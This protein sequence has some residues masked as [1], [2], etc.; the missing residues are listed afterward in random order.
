MWLHG[1]INRILL[2]VVDV[3]DT[4]DVLKI[5][6]KEIG[7]SWVEMENHVEIHNKFII[8]YRLEEVKLTYYNDAGQNV[9]YLHYKGS[10]K[11]PALRKT[12]VKMPAKM[13]NITALFNAARLLIT[14][15]IKT[16]TVGSS[17]IRL[18][19]MTFE[20]PIDDV[21]VVDKSKI[22]SEELDEEEKQ[23]RLEEKA[24][25]ERQRQIRRAERK[26]KNEERR[27]K[28][29]KRLELDKLK[30]KAAS[31]RRFLKKQALAR[32]ARIKELRNKRNLGQ[33]HDLPHDNED[34][35]LQK[36]L[37]VEPIAPEVAFAKDVPTRPKTKEESSEPDQDRS[38]SDPST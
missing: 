27:Q 18:L 21:M 19:G 10:T 7:L 3:N 24:E 35:E 15:N 22:V 12:V 17:R 36:E 8:P 1:L 20:L 29:K 33:T 25:R 13:S 32:L 6:T 23:R 4:N 38:Y 30:R 5:I 37:P 11:I 34:T 2:K 16:R 31:E 26:T 9:G 14:D 28:L